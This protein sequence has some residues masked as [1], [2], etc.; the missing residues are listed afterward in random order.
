MDIREFQPAFL[1]GLIPCTPGLPD[2]C[3]PKRHF[4]DLAVRQNRAPYSADQSSVSG[5]SGSPPS[6]D[7]DARVAVAT[8]DG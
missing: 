5:V 8:E 6:A 1:A 3:K 7:A 4:H 2:R